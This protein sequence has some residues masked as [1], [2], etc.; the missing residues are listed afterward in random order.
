M[1]LFFFIA[2]AAAKYS[3]KNRSKK[4]YCLERLNRLLIP[5]CFSIIVLIPPI[6]Y[7]A[8]I[9]HH[10]K[11]SF[12]QYY[13]LFFKIDYKH[14]DGFTGTFTP[15]NLW[16]ILYLFCF[17][18]ITL[19]LFD[20]FKTSKGEN[21]IALILDSSLFKYKAVIF[22]C[23]IPLT[24]ARIVTLVYYNPVYYLI[25]FILG[26]LVLLDKRF[27]NLIEQNNT[28]ALIFAVPG[29]LFYFYS[30]INEY[31][32]VFGEFHLV[33]LLIQFLLSLTS[34]CWLIVLLN[35]ARRY[36]NWS[37]S[38]IAYFNQASYPIYIIHA[39]FLIPIA[40]YTIQWDIAIFVKF[41]FITFSTFCS[42]LLVYHL[43][44]KRFQVTR[45][46]FGMK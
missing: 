43:F 13:P 1:P 38:L 26:Y 45:F 33:N 25:F 19:P 27:E 14:L 40:F 41:C 23:V 6:G 39:T 17:S 3:L 42:V 2:G 44:I 37:N 20:Y 8:Y 34:Y 7:F 5:L 11:I 35:F 22:L 10:I 29:T 21:F 16:F 46:L 30:G 4:Q 32:L 12:F 15:G 24:F 31:F 9:H 36:L 28:V 18:L